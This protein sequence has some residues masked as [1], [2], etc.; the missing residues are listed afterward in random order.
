M[1]AAGTAARRSLSTLHLPVKLNPHPP[2]KTREERRK[3][4]NEKQTK[5]GNKNVW[6]GGTILFSCNAINPAGLVDILSLFML[7]CTTILNDAGTV[8]FEG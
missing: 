8:L 1:Q 2:K 6:V 5:N 3:N 4:E 7:T